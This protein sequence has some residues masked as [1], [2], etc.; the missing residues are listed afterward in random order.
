MPEPPRLDKPLSFLAAQVDAAA[1]EE[2]RARYR[3]FRL[4][5]AEG[6]KG[7]LVAAT[8][9]GRRP[10]LFPAEDDDDA[11][12]VDAPAVDEGTPDPA[13]N[14]KLIVFYTVPLAGHIRVASALV[15]NQTYSAEC[16]RWTSPTRRRT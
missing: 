14:D 13:N 15:N 5:G 11:T 9:P 6:A 10:G 3:F 12:D 8:T 16:A 1:L 2:Y 7:E 4:G